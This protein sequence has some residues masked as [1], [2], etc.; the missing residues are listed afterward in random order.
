MTT[1]S[2][3]AGHWSPDG[4]LMVRFKPE[5]QERLNVLVSGGASLAQAIEILVA[6]RN[7]KRTA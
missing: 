3:L 1:K 4:K 6:E 5:L 2:L 7:G